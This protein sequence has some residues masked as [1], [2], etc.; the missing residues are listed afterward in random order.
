MVLTLAFLYPFRFDQLGN[1]LLC[2]SDDGHVFLMDGRASENFKVLGH[3]GKALVQLFWDRK[4]LNELQNAW[5]SI[6]KDVQDNSE[7]LT[8]IQ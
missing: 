5:Y 8:L 7:T 4:H 1:F 3:T 6:R 2:S